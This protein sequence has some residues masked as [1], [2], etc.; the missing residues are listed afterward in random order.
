MQHTTRWAPGLNFS[1]QAAYEL[2][3][4]VELY[5]EPNV[6]MIGKHI[7]PGTKHPMEGEGKLLFGT[8]IKF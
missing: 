3:P 6:T 4:S 1:A 5:A 8:R 7:T 2:S